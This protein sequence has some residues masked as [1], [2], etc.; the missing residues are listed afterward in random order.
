MRKSWP[1]KKRTTLDLHFLF[2]VFVLFLSRRVA[3]NSWSCNLE[4]SETGARFHTAPLFECLQY[5]VQAYFRVEHKLHWQGNTFLH[6]LHRNFRY[7]RASLTVLFSF[8]RFGQ[9]LLSTVPIILTS[10]ALFSQV[11]LWPLQQRL[12]ASALALP[13]ATINQSNGTDGW[14]RQARMLE[15]RDRLEVYLTL[16]EFIS[17]SFQGKKMRCTNLHDLISE[18]YTCCGLQDLIMPHLL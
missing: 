2:L 16:Y 7:T 6:K 5:A 12:H 17:V 13:R 14:R 18:W 1:R 15:T 4:L 8:F 10:F 3:A 11:A 9:S